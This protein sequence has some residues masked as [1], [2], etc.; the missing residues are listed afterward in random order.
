[1][2]KTL[3][4]VMAFFLTWQ[5]PA[6]YSQYIIRLRDK[7]QSSFQLSKPEAFLSQRSIDR[8][9]RYKI[10]LDSSDLPISKTYLDAIRNVPNVTIK[11]G[12]KWL[13]QVL[14]VTT[15]PAALAQLNALPF[16]KSLAPAAM[17][18]RP[19]DRL[20]L[21]QKFEEPVG[22]KNNS[23]ILSK[24]NNTYRS[25]ETGAIAHS[26]QLRNQL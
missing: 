25:H 24:A 18:A 15:D 19:M 4:V 2:K 9:T 22:Y 26:A 20:P 1:M 17:Q 5:L 21:N 7:G 16:V 11:N 8:R 12:S 3:A 13:N 6:Q 23:S 10:S 14:I